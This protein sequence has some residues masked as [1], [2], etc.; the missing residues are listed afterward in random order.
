MTQM[1]V[2]APKQAV[3]RGGRHQNSDPKVM[4]TAGDTS[5]TTLFG[6]YFHTSI[7]KLLFL[8]GNSVLRCVK[9]RVLALFYKNIILS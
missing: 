6:H 1:A 2:G 9:K 7:F 4:K 8:F 5:K 3:F